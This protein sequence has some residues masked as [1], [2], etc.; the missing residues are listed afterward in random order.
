MLKAPA[1]SCGAGALPGPGGSAYLTFLI[2]DIIRQFPKHFHGLARERGFGSP[3]LASPYG[4]GAGRRGERGWR[5]LGSAP[6]RA[7][8]SPS[9]GGNFS[10]F[11]LF[12]HS[13][14]ASLAYQ[15]QP[16]C[17]PAQQPAAMDTGRRDPRARKKK[18]INDKKR[19]LRLAEP[20]RGGAVGPACLPASR[21][22]PRA[23]ACQR[24]GKWPVKLKRLPSDPQ[25][26]WG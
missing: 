5:R 4:G 20:R 16:N 8:R 14:I 23:S 1:C 24:G 21:G 13:L 6:V 17:S 11:Q 2:L 9:N 10:L 25:K 26:V 12:T 22:Y 19:F 3:C 18:K 7:R 15:Q